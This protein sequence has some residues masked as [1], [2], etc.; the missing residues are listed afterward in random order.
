MSLF[1]GDLAFRATPRGD[2]VKLAVF[3]G[4][5]VSAVAGL[6]VLAAASR[7]REPSL[8]VARQGGARQN[9]PDRFQEPA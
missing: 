4:S 2:E 3:V 7:R 5:I 9:A 8:T 6:C 1:I